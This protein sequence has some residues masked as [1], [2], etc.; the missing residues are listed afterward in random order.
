MKSTGIPLKTK[1]RNK[2]QNVNAKHFLCQCIVSGRSC[3]PSPYRPLHVSLIYIYIYISF[4]SGPQFKKNWLRKL[5]T[6]AL[7]VYFMILKFNYGI[8][9][10]I[11]H[12]SKCCLIPVTLCPLVVILLGGGEMGI[13]IKYPLGYA[14]SGILYF[15]TPALI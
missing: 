5:R 13:E 10:S 6:I 8:Q 3:R 14:S 2:T 1:I 15:V 11:I 7:P 9:L 12:V 4:F